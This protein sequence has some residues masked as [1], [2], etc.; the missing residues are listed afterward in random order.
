M[1]K[2]YVNH[3]KLIELSNYLNDKSLD[4]ENLIEKMLST[5]D[6]IQ[7]AWDGIDSQVFIANA[8]NYIEN[9]RKI[10]AGVLGCSASMMKNE[11]R[12]AN[13]FLDYFSRYDEENKL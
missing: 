2:L 12:Y 13:A 10:Q 9:L 5:V 4:I 8:S 3:E 7:N 6:S 11:N 1:V